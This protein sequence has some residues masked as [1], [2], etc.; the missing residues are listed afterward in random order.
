VV[1]VELAGLVV[2]SAPNA[3]VLPFAVSAAA[4]AVNL[5]VSTSKVL[6]IIDR[7]ELRSTDSRGRLSPHG[8]GWASAHAAS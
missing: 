5:V 4:K 8:C 3:R 2:G 6:P 7:V 1:A